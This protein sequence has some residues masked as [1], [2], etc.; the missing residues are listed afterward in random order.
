MSLDWMK[1]LKELKEM[2]DSGILSKEE[3]ELEKKV[4]MNSR[5]SVHSTP[6]SNK[7]QVNT[8]T[9]PLGGGQG[10]I[11]QSPSN[12]NPLSGS[13]GTMIHQPS[14]SNPLGS[15]PLSGGQSTI[16]GLTSGM[17]VGDYLII[18]VIGEGGMGTVYKGRHHNEEFAK[19][20][21]YV[22]IKT[23]KPEYANNPTFK[24]RFIREA[25]I[26]R[27]IKH[28]NIADCLGFVDD[29][30]HLALVMSFVAGKELKEMIVKGGMNI[31]EVIR[32]IRPIADALDYLHSENIVHRDIKP[33]NI[34][35]D[36]KGIPIILDMGIAKDTSGDKGKGQTKTS[37][38]MGTLPYMAPE[39]YTDAKSVDGKADQ[40]ALGM[41]VYEML[42]GRFPWEEGTSEFNIG[43]NKAFDRLQKLNEICEIDELIS[44]IIKKCL[45]SDAKNR[46]DSCSEFVEAL[47]QSVEKIKERID[48]KKTKTE[49]K[50][51]SEKE[52][53]EQPKAKEKKKELENQ[54][55]EKIRKEDRSKSSKVIDTKKE[56]DGVLDSEEEEVLTKYDFEVMTKKQLI[57]YAQR[58]GIKYKVSWKKGVILQKILDSQFEPETDLEP[59]D[60]KQTEKERIETE[61][62]K[63]QR[64]E[65]ARRKEEL[66]RKEQE[67]KVE[68]KRREE[69]QRQKEEDAA[70]HQKWEKKKE[71]DIERNK[72]FVAPFKNKSHWHSQYYI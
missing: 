33:E 17:R 26:G 27:R 5:K 54:N 43:A 31:E 36:K 70:Q 39:Q 68:K 1:Q 60:V 37:T 15:N 57:E 18:D 55:L 22:A 38:G 20:G 11:I 10:T 49:N 30:Q 6:P 3:Y 12:T 40:Y 50:R 45:T 52:E 14:T 53:E 51:L 24:S 41:M 2:Y 58:H 21:G 72:K 67:K 19:Q 35:V 59:S 62:K 64:K 48:N 13:Q 66:K 71:I 47:S 34:K 4:I 25:G 65:D 7:E 61:R 44:D 46:F 63:E 28:N 23:M 9:N 56:S 32:Y 16:I 69:E 8:G 42:S 29:G